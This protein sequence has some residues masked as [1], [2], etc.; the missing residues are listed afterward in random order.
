[1]NKNKYDSYG[2]LSSIPWEDIEKGDEVCYKTTLIVGDRGKITKELTGIWDGEKVEF[3]D[4]NKHIIRTT[5]WLKK[6]KL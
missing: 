1:M 4:E 3:D 5:R 2:V 6:I